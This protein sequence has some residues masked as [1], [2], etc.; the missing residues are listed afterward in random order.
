M[1]FQT[2]WENLSDTPIEKNIPVDLPKIRGFVGH[3]AITFL[4]LITNAY[5][6]MTDAGLTLKSQ[7]LLKIKA[8]ILQDEPDFIEI[9][10]SNKGP[11]IPENDLERIFEAGFTTKKKGTGLGLNICK[12]IVEFYNN[13]SIYA[14][15]IPDF[16]PEFVIKLPRAKEVGK[17]D[18]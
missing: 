7:R 15:N 10:V 2:Y 17:N 1:R 9:C 12:S 18:T 8:S 4:N 3:L 16:G 13:G 14:R 6:A 5:Q 11:L